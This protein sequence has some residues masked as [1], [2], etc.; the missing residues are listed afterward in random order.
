[1]KC[2]FLLEH[3]EHLEPHDVTAVVSVI[4]KVLLLMKIH[5]RQCPPSLFRDKNFRAYISITRR[6]QKFPKNFPKTI[7]NIYQTKELHRVLPEETDDKDTDMECGAVRIR[8]SAHEKRGYEMIGGFQN[9]DME[10]NGENQL[11]RA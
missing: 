10:K 5:D 3:H 8:D 7:P 2:N 6:P 9:V 1:M 4:F 11:E